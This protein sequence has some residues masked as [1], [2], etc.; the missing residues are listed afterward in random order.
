MRIGYRVSVQLC[1]SPG[2]QLTELRNKAPSLQ[3]NAHTRRDVLHTLDT[4]EDAEMTRT[5]K[6]VSSQMAENPTGPIETVS[7]SRLRL[8]TIVDRRPEKPGRC[9]SGPVKGNPSAQFAQVNAFNSCS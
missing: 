4:S 9:I 3:M 7:L 5:P 6:L 1:M 8:C 2:V